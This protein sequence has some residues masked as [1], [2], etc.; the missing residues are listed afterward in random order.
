MSAWNTRGRTCKLYPQWAV[1]TFKSSLSSSSPAPS[2][3][4]SSTSEWS[5]L[6]LF[7]PCEI[8]HLN[9][10]WI[11]VETPQ[12]QLLDSCGRSS[13]VP[14]KERNEIK[15]NTGPLQ[16]LTTHTRLFLC[17]I[18]SLINDQHCC[19]V[20]VQAQIALMFGGSEWCKKNSPQICQTKSNELVLKLQ[21]EK[22]T[23]VFLKI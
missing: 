13:V 21:E 23:D 17:D 2:F 3:S 14:K 5:C 12:P 19:C 18:M 4:S 10:D 8:Q 6:V 11:D 16:P 15:N 1:L 9:L 22:S 20:T 7:S